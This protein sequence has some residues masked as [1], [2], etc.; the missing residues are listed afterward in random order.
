[1][2]ARNLQRKRLL[3]IGRKV[4]AHILAGGSVTS[5]VPGSGTSRARL[6]RA[7]AYLAKHDAD[8]ADILDLQPIEK[9]RARRHEDSTDS[10]TS[11]DPLLL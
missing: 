5:F 8:A 7:M 3:I 11:I 6:Y 9:K 10:E 1:M 2:F 4:K